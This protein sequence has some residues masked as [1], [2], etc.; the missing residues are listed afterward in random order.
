M[1]ILTTKGLLAGIAA[2][3]L[4]L[5]VAQCAKADLLYSTTY[6]TTTTPTMFLETAPTVDRVLTSPVVIDRPSVIETPS[7]RVIDR[8][9]L[10]NGEGHHLLNLK[11]F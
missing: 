8:P 6:E 4:G 7:T 2:G 10:M 3:F 9:I 5:T 1:R 11:L